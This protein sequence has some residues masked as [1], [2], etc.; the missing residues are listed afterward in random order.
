MN[1]DIDND[2]IFAA[3]IEDE[4]NPDNDDLYD[5]QCPPVTTAPKP[6]NQQPTETND[7]DTPPI[8]PQNPTEAHPD[9]GGADDEIISV[10]W[11]KGTLAVA[12]F[13]LDSMEMSVADETFDLQPDY[14]L[15]HNLFRTTSMRHIIV[16]GPPGFL[17]QV[18]QL[19]RLPFVSESDRTV[20]LNPMRMCRPQLI[21]SQFM[22]IYT[23]EEKILA[24][25]RRRILQ[26]HLPEM[27]TATLLTD[28][29]R[30]TFI[31]NI[32]PLHQP[33]VVLA[34]GNLLCFLDANWRY[35][36]LV[37]ESRVVLTDLRVHR[38]ADAV[39]MDESTGL[40]LQIF[41]PVEQ[42]PSGMKKGTGGT[43][44][45]GRS[46]GRDG[47]SLYAALVRNCASRCG[48]RH[49]RTL[50]LQP[51]Q[52]VGELRQRQRAIGWCLARLRVAPVAVAATAAGARGVIDELR[53]RL[54]VIANPSEIY[55]RLTTRG[56][57]PSDWRLLQRAAVNIYKI[58]VLCAQQLANP[59]AVDNGLDSDDDGG[60]CELIRRLASGQEQRVLKNMLCAMYKV[61][62][63][64]TSL[65]QGSFVVRD[66]FDAELDELREQMLNIKRHLLELCQTEV[67]TFPEYVGQCVI[68]YFEHYGFLLGVSVPDAKH[69]H[70]LATVRQRLGP[71]FQLQHQD[72][73]CMYFQT[74]KSKLF[75]ENYGT[76]YVDIVAREKHI[77][78]RLLGFVYQSVQAAQLMAR[79]CARLDCMLAMAQ[80]SAEQQLVRPDVL[81]PPAR[82][83]NIVG[84]K[85]MMLMLQHQPLRPCTPN[86]TRL[87]ELGECRHCRMCVL[88]ASNAAG[89]SVYL[90]Q[91]GLI[92]YMAHIGCYVPAVSAQIG[93]LDGIYSRIYSVESTHQG[94]SAFL[95]DLRQMSKALMES[96]GRSLILIDEFGKGTNVT[97]GRAI[98]QAGLEHLLERREA[99]PLTLVST[100]YR[101]V[102]EGV[103][104][105][106]PAEVTDAGWTVLQQSFEMQR[107]A[108]GELR[109]TFRLIEGV[110]PEVYAEHC[111]EVAQEM[112]EIMGDP[113]RCGETYN[114]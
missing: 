22:H 38:L 36:Y 5:V 32:L 21:G 11:S 60:G 53:E 84:G 95:N 29:E 94:G 70:F 80:L 12:H 15:L 82:G 108:A 33:M 85:H 105:A 50:M 97:E 9:A 34:V 75:N 112:R 41:S 106:M 43:S 111:D 42:H 81:P 30:Q 83:L 18:A 4:T 89:K 44:T 19:C 90:K 110:G 98:L 45:A 74:G 48:S 66:G 35:L 49:L 103:M 1:S 78:Q 101:D 102:A 86:D 91:V 40:A 114:W 14:P 64:G 23:N 93:C 58:S 62:D 54:R 77:G 51:T 2:D 55:L 88:N 63:I 99:S 107:S 7:V 28:A 6:I 59:A 57:R 47:F 113:L 73:S 68:L 71:S 20:D 3:I 39:L 46:S 17:Q 16:S 65:R 24:T 61:M 76:L 56:N 96:S 67:A 79:L 92:A 69:A 87:G 10:A 72:A 100:H 37:T 109:S 27:D 8:E 13:R 52:D 31:G 25:N 26:I 104:R